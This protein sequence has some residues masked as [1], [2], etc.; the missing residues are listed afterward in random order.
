[1]RA[2][3][4][5]TKRVELSHAPTA[6]VTRVLVAAS[7]ACVFETMVHQFDDGAP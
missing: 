4:D 5:V 3:N 7:L 6:L 1:M 2:L